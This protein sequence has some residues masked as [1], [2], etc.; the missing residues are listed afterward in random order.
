LNLQTGEG[1]RDVFEGVDRA[2][3]LSPTGFA[4]QYSILSPLI[5]ESKRR[6]LKKVVMMTAMGAN[7]NDE[8]PLRRAEIELEKSGLRYNIIRPN[9]FMD[10]FSTFWINA[11][12]AGTL[13]LPARDAKTSF[14]DTRDIAAVAARLLTDDSLSNKDFDLTGRE[15]LTHKEIAEMISSVAAHPVVYKNGTPEG[16]RAG[17]LASG[18][19]ADYANLLVMIMGFLAEGYSERQTSA[20]KDITGREPRTFA[21]Y[22]KEHAAHF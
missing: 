5:Q 8:M 13:E 10:N 11:V 18:A 20:V 22:A 9:W 15:S 4:D 17:L 3:F 21:A 19:P 16:L 2:F 14:I 12:R 6:G 7:A 1:L